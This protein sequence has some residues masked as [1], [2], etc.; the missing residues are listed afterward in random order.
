[1]RTSAQDDKI[2][3]GMAIDTRLVAEPAH[4][5]RGRGSAASLRDPSHALTV[6]AH[7]RPERNGCPGRALT[8]LWAPMCE[9]APFAGDR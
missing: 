1:M 5:V 4:S 8:V 2:R 3:L 9:T 6:A 7:H